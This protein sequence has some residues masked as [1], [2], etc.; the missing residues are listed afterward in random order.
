MDTNDGKTKLLQIVRKVF[1]PQFS[2][3]NKAMYDHVISGLDDKGM[4]GP[5]DFYGYVN[6]MKA[7]EDLWNPCQSYAN[8]SVF[9]VFDRISYNFY[10][11]N[12]ICWNFLSH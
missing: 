11:F 4:R 3:K 7:E 9:I 10:N 5:S 2:R 8:P 1:E 6:S 12:R